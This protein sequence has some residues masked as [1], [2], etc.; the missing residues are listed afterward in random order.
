MFLR[1]VSDDLFQTGLNLPNEHLPP[2]LGAPDQVVDHEMDSVSFMLIAH[3]YSIALSTMIGKSPPP[4][5]QIR[6]GALIRRMDDGGF[7]ALGL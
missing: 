4:K 1:Y 5:L 6:S 3:V 7:P 2:S